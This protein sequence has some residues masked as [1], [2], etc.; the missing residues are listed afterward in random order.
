MRIGNRLFPYPIIN[1]NESLTKYDPSSSFSIVYD[2]N[3]DG[4]LPQ[5]DNAIL[6][7]NVHFE[8]VDEK[9]NELYYKGKIGCTLIVESSAAIYRETFELTETPQDILIFLDNV[10]NE[11]VVSAYLYAKED[12]IDYSSNG[13][14]FRYQN[15][16]FDIEKYSILAADDGFSIPIE[17]DPRDD[18]RVSSIFTI[19]QR[20]ADE[21]KM[22]YEMKQ[23]GIF[24][25]LPS[26][27][28]NYYE[29]VKVK[30]NYHTLQFALLV[31]P[32]LTSCIQMIQKEYDPS[33]SSMDEIA[34]DYKWMR[35]ICNSYKRETEQELSIDEFTSIPAFE[36]SQIVLN[37]SNTKGLEAF[38]DLLLNGEEGDDDE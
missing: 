33:T 9:L 1:K 35:S 5:E 4:T 32:V 6:L 38:H 12:I 24:I 17:H 7:K 23:N 28:Y 18:N 29:T 22:S 3:E 37:Y 16:T 21:D 30:A 11:A 15:Y 2:V 34:D 27:Y 25:Y 31:M 13:F 10:K 19:V 36:L 20:E 14:S 8:L 26:K